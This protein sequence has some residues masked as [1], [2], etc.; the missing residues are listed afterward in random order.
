MNKLFKL[1][2]V[3]TLICFGASIHGMKRKNETDLIV[4]NSNDT[5]QIQA[6]PQLPEE[7]IYKIVGD[8]LP[9]EKNQFMRTCRYICACLK[10]RQLILRAN[11]ATVGVTDKVEALIKYAHDGDV[12]MTKFLLDN[13]VDVNWGN[14]LCINPI[15]DA[16][17]NVIP[18]LVERGADINEPKP[19]IH[20]LH[21]AV[22][23]GDKN[24]VQALLASKANPNIAITND[25]IPLLI[26]SYK[27]YIEIVKLLLATDGIEVNK[28]ANNGVTPLN[29]ASNKGLTE[30]VQLLLATDGIKVNEEAL[31]G[32]TPLLVASRNGQTEI[33]KLLLAAGADVNKAKN[34]GIT[35][36]YIASYNG[37]AQ[38]IQLLLAAG[39]E[40]N[41]ADNNEFTP[42]YMASRN[43]HTEIVKLLLAADGIEVNKANKDGVVPL[44]I[45]SN[46]GYIEIVKLLLASGV[47]VNKADRGGWTPLCAV[48]YYSGNIEV[49]KLLLSYGAN[50]YATLTD[51]SKVDPLIKAGDTALDIAQ[52]KGHIQVVELLKSE[53]QHR[54]TEDRLLRIIKSGRI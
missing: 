7:M 3:I 17:A 6:A 39:A 13:G 1:S 52:K 34:D 32:A 48:A 23:A 24:I 41:K 8:C 31:D 42:L 40:V 29:I 33:V 46:F 22:Y 49:V 43:G 21:E 27:G 25:I 37:H 15:F 19:Q 47:D 5:N 30:I 14:I 51:N 54:E 9:K 50:I 45:A 2:L 16:H 12:N 28:A 53:L 38:I 11:L 44:H 26:A 20:R 18:L 4:Q 10:N 35:P 36:L